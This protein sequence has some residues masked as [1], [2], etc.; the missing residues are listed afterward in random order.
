MEAIQFLGT[1]TITSAGGGMVEVRWIQEYAGRWRFRWRSSEE[2][3]LEGAGNTPPTPA[4]KELVVA[5]G[6][7]RWTWS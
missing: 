4:L 3:L 1:T 7:I 2:L 6:G 5:L